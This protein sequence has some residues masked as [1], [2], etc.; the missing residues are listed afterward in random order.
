MTPTDRH[1]ALVTA[2]QESGWQRAADLGAALGVSARTIYRDMEAL[3]EVG[4]PVVGMPGR[5]YRLSETYFLPALRLTTDEAMLLLLALDGAEAGRETPLRAAAASARQK[6]GE[7][8]PERLRAEVATRQQRLRFEPANVF[9]DAAARRAQALLREAWHAQRAVRLGREGRVV[10]PYGLVHVGA[11]WHL[12]GL[13]VARQR[14]ETIALGGI[15]A[16]EVL[17]ETFERPAG[18]TQSFEP[19]AS[20]ERRVRVRFE[21]SLAPLVE[22]A[23]SAYRVETET[24]AEGFVVTLAIERE[25]EILPWLLS[26][27]AHAEVLEPASLRRRLAREAAALAARYPAEPSLLT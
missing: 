11:A 5:G 27:G 6:L 20:R 24:T 19:V 8:L 10:H 2:L 12:L 23:A 4:V 15:K 17:E 16:V 7:I 13:D 9:D 22:Q 21:A 3:V 18:Y 1:L 14:V 26:W 25:A